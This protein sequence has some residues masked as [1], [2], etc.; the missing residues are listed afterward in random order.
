MDLQWAA[1]LGNLSQD[2]P[3][4]IT[5]VNEAAS[6][7]WSRGRRR[8]ALAAVRQ[9]AVE[10]REKR[11]QGKTEMRDAAVGVEEAQTER[12]TLGRRIMTFLDRFAKP[13]DGAYLRPIAVAH[14]CYESPNT[15]F[16][17]VNV[18]IMMVQYAG[19][20]VPLHVG[21]DYAQMWL[22]LSFESIRGLTDAKCLKN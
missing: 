6:T 7:V 16:D 10:V 2:A 12:S 11:Q 8:R 4:S 17:L 13:W 20:D 18:I 21:G 15:V 19:F 3:P 14:F 1:S 5:P 9:R 22:Y